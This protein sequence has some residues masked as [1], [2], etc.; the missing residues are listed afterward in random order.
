MNREER[1]IQGIDLITVFLYLALVLIGWMTIYAVGFSGQETDVFNLDSS[2]GKQMLWIG[3]SL[4]VGAAIL[5]I[6]YKF[7]STF[8]FPIYGLILLM[9]AAA[10]VLAPEVKGARSWFDIGPF[11]FQPSELGK[12][13]TALALAKYVTSVNFNIRTLKSKA[14][15][16]GLILLPVV[17]ILAQNDTGSA[18]VYLGLFLVLYR[19][20]FPVLLPVIGILLGI[21]FILTIIFGAWPIVIAVA[22][23]FGAMILYLSLNFRFNKGKIFLLGIIMLVSAAF[24]VFV[25][26]PVYYNVL[27]DH[28]RSR[29]NVLLGKEFGEGADYNVLQA[30]IAIGS[31]GLEGK[32]YLQGTITKGKFVPEQ[33]TDFIF[34][35]LSEEW[36]FIGATVFILLFIMLLIRITQLSE[37]QRSRFPKVYGYGVASILFIH[38]AINV[39]MAIGVFPVIGIPLPFLS[40]GGSSLIGFTILLAI[41][42]KLD[43]NRMIYLR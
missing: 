32:G 5:I 13:A 7:Y 15:A 29:I 42:L 35:T 4:I 3:V 9:M 8:A 39:G 31:G 1:S 33:N 43:A 17:I 10:I 22:V 21:L 18:L 20:G 12:F 24:T 40:Y 19:E 2:H 11:R 36:G 38:F 41:L 30:K 16:I 34:T 23:I 37:R 14:I 25:V 27:Q 26:E 28:Q 6:N